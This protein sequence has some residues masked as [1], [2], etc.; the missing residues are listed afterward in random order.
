MSQQVNLFNPAFR[1][2]K[3]PF[4]AATMLQCAGVIL[5]GSLGVAAYLEWQMSSLRSD[6]EASERQLK[7]VKA[8]LA[9]ANADFAPRQKDKALEDELQRMEVELKSRQQAFD[10]VQRGGMGNSKGHAEFLQAF[11]RQVV[12]GLWLTGFTISGNDIEL[13]GRALQPELV[14]AFINRLKQEPVMQGKSFATLAMEMP[15]APQPAG[16]ETVN[17]TA[18]SKRRLSAGY[19]EF[20]LRSSEPV[21]EQPG[22]PGVAGVAAIPDIPGLPPGLQGGVAK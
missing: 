6:A 16:A 19:I 4:S 3:K 1:K 17:A 13:H 10:I 18:V 7:S 14:P 5:M 21:P 8:Q 9:K 15:P 12:N 2:Q 22:A 11:S 20:S